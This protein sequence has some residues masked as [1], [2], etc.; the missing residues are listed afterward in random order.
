M[1]IASPSHCGTIL[2]IDDDPAINDAFARMLTLEGHQV[3]TVRDA[4]T[5]LQQLDILA[6]DAILV[7][8]RMP[9]VDGL[10]F[11]RRLRA[12]PL[13]RDLPVAI[14]T[15]D[16][17]ID[18]TLA[19]EL[20][21]LGAEVRFKPVWCGDLLGI[22]Q[23]LLR[24]AAQAPRVP[25]HGQTLPLGDALQRRTLLLVDDSTAQRD[26]YEMALQTHFNILTASRGDEGVTIASREHPDVIV[27]DVMMPGLDG[28]QTCRRLKSNEHTASI[29]VIFLTSRDDA[30][31]ATQVTDVGGSVVLR[32]PCPAEEL[33]RTIRLTLPVH[34]EG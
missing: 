30:D 28:W 5:G 6:P 34:A 17:F 19:K 9:N 10:E 29:P 23:D 7:D 32:K 8:L 13:Y 20:T 22:A 16:R 1:K 14:V 2:V 11:L 4:E 18:E 27:L 26:L 25:K 15:G 12:Q 24:L 31:L 3:H 21:S 33:L